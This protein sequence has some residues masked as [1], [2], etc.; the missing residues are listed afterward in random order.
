MNAVQLFRENVSQRP[1]KVAFYFEDDIWT[2]KRV[3]K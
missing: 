2:F 3:I 1:D